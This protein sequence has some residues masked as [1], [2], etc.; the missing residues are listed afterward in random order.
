MSIGQALLPFE[1]LHV[2]TGGFWHAAA[3]SVRRYE[4]RHRD[5]GDDWTFMTSV[6]EVSY[7]EPTER[8][9]GPGY[10]RDDFSGE[11]LTPGI[12]PNLAFALTFMHGDSVAEQQVF[13]LGY[14]RLAWTRTQPHLLEVFK[15]FGRA[16]RQRAEQRER[17]TGQWSWA[18]AS[19]VG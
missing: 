18:S 16:A 2:G 10:G 9:C 5:L 8:S 13:S 15:D 7:C 14:D 11:V 17:R 6:Y 12:H 19:H 1:F 3:E 4:E